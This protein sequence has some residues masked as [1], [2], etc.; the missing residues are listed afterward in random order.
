LQTK[1]E[2]KIQIANLTELQKSLIL[3]MANTCIDIENLKSTEDAIK[4]HFQ[5]N[6]SIT[7]VIK[8]IKKGSMGAYGVSHK[9]TP[10]VIGSWI[11][12]YQKEYS[13]DRL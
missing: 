12:Q 4:K 3:A 13:R 2:N 5:G 7:T 8:A 10:Q 9:L 6:F 11:Y 1:S